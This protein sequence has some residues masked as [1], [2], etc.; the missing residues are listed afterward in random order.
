MLPFLKITFGKSHSKYYPKA[1]KL[2]RQ[3][4]D[5]SEISPDGPVN[6][7][8][9]STKEEFLKRHSDFFELWHIIANWVSI[10]SY[11]EGYE[12]KRYM[13]VGI[14]F[15]KIRDISN[16]KYRK[17]DELDVHVRLLKNPQ[18]KSQRIIY[19]DEQ[20]QK[21]VNAGGVSSSNSVWFLCREYL[22]V[23]RKRL[24]GILIYS[25]ISWAA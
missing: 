12:V 21:K 9:F 13:E 18:K 7:V 2:L 25:N 15:S 24:N 16:Y 10:K 22:N 14:V 17:F 19:K 6:S 11:I 5:H 3:F 8:S 20:T 1:L 4:P 23:S